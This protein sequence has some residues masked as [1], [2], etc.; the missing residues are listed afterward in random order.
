METIVTFS[1]NQSKHTD[2][3]RSLKMFRAFFD[4]T[5]S[6]QSKFLENPEKG[7]L[8]LKQT[9]FENFTL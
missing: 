9:D 1:G 7:D 3:C 5:G 6:K 4:L 8:I 2:T